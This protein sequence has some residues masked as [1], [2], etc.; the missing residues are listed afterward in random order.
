M[1]HRPSLPSSPFHATSGTR[2]S[3]MSPPTGSP[4]HQFSAASTL[5]SGSSLDNIT[6]VEVMRI[7]PYI[8][9]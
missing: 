5:V 6:S 3:H 4:Q 8:L 7:L 2:R 9:L 1:A